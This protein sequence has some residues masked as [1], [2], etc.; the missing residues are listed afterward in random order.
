[1]SEFFFGAVTPSSTGGQPMQLYLLSKQNVSPG[2]GTS[3]LTQKFIVYQILNTVISIV[4]V[5]IDFKYFKSAFTGIWST[6]F[7]ALGFASQLLVPALFVNLDFSKKLTD[8]LLKIVHKLIIK[9]KI[10]KNPDLIMQRIYD[11]LRIFRSGNNALP[12]YKKKI[13]AVYCLV[14]LQIIAILSVPYFI[15]LSFG[16]PEIS[17]ENGAET[18]NIFEII[19]IQ[20]FV[21]FTSNL[22]PLPGAS[23]GA[24]LAFGMYFR[25]FFNIGGHNTIK[26]AILLWRFVTYYGA[27]II[28][29]PFSYFTSGKKSEKALR[30]EQGAK[31]DDSA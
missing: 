18:L 22:I 10:I 15:Y 23:G 8:F 30:E 3:C 9:I 21:M 13:L 19:C 7:I 29:A 27:I 14:F 26:S 20:S 24:E 16:M 11:E 25:P 28:S 17:A 2:F 6:L 5:L 31:S 1:M 12:K 4:A